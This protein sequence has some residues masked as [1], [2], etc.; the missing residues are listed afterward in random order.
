MDSAKP[1]CHETYDFSVGSPKLVLSLVDLAPTI[2][3]AIR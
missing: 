3:F 1:A 2:R